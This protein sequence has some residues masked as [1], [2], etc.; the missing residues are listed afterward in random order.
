[1]E[2]GD[3]QER[4]NGQTMGKRRKKK[5]Y[6]LRAMAFLL[7]A[8]IAGAGI[9]LYPAWRAAGAL[10]DK[11]SLCCGS[12]ELEAEL[13]REKLSQEQE[14]MFGTLAWLTGIREEAMYRLCIRGNIQEDKV[15]LR[16][17]PD[18]MAEPLVELYLGN[19]ISVINES[20]LY[21]A[22]RS[23]LT[24]RFGLLDS[25]M[26]RQEEALY[27][28]LEQVEQLFGVDLGGLDGFDLSAAVRKMTATKCFLMLAVMPREKQGDGYRFALESEQ[29]QLG[30]DVPDGEED[31]ALG[32]ELAVR[33]VPETAAWADRFFSLLGSRR[34]GEEL[35]ILK[36]FSMSIEWYEDGA[37][38]IPTNL[39]N[40]G[41]IE[42]I[43]GIRAW[44][45]RTFGEIGGVL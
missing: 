38:T 16:I 14:K 42:T 23:N 21:N 11:M 33:D 12:F 32:M 22:V 31:R 39:V 3:G 36:S 9:Y 4:G 20:M 34:P 1:M 10:A 15:H 43:A 17:Y 6:V 40:Q 41:T 30:I 26:P 44:I 24:E 45:Q 19:D 29:A 25:L 35:E 18:G 28:T 7:A 2:S 5:R 8:V 37:V 13:A 27:M